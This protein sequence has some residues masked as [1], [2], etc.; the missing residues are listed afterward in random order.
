MWSIKAEK[1]FYSDLLKMTRNEKRH[2][3]LSLLY[4]GRIKYAYFAFLI[5]VGL[6]FFI[7]GINLQSVILIMIGVGLFSFGLGVLLKQLLDDCL[8]YKSIALILKVLSEEKI[9]SQIQF[10]NK[11]S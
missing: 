8:A 4:A 3:F 6:L 11:S 5:I 9:K 2:S 1:K 10:Y 7:F